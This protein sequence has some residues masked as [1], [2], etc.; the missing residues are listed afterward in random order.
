MP[1]RSTNFTIAATDQLPLSGTTANIGG[2]AL[3]SGNC[4][5]G[6]VSIF[7][8]TTAMAVVVTGA[9][10]TDPG[11]NYILRGYVSASGTV[12]VN[13]CAIASGT[14]A[15]QTYNVRVIQ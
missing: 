8:A 3:S 1:S 15:A 2:S 5:T 9:S 4:A 14:P 10:G 11:A 13:L 6:M 7:G 12:T